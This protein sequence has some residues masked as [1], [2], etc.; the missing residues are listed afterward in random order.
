MKDGKFESTGE[1]DAYFGD[2]ILRCLICGK[3]FAGLNQHLVRGHGVGA[4]EYKETYGIP[5]K[6]GLLGAD[7]RRRLSISTMA[8]NAAMPD[9]IM[10][11]RLAKMREHHRARTGQ[12]HAPVVTNARKNTAY[13]MH[14]SPNHPAVRGDH[15]LGEDAFCVD[16]GATVETNKLAA[17]AKRNVLLCKRC[18]F[19]HWYEVKKRWISNN[20]KRW[21]AIQ[22]RYKARKSKL[23][24]GIVKVVA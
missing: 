11:E 4:I 14:L 1:L 9:D 15:L 6:Y 8:M 24:A 7:S 3:R 12:S 2:D 19:D 13:D 22:Q 20:P 18:R 23:K 17:V 5:F 21:K 16:C 10:M